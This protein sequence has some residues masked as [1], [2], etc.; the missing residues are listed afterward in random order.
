MGILFYAIL[1]GIYVINLVV[2]GF[3]NLRDI[4]LLMRWLKRGQI[5]DT[6]IPWIIAIVVL[7]III[8]FYVT[9]HQK[10]EGAIEFFRRVLRFG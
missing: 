2:V 7:V 1:S 4:V 9:L 3:N 10:G 6:M 8:G 5:W